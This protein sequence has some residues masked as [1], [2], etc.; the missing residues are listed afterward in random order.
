MRLAIYRDTKKFL[1]SRIAVHIGIDGEENNDKTFEMSKEKSEDPFYGY[2][3]K[4]KMD[5]DIAPIYGNC[6]KKDSKL[7]M[8]S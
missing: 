4:A 8:W 6:L 1:S 2:D 7:V 5:F 3:H